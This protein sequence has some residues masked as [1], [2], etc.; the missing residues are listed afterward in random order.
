MVKYQ[1][2]RAS[3]PTMVDVKTLNISRDH[4]AKGLAV[5]L[6]ATLTQ[7]EL[8]S[9]FPPTVSMDTFRDIMTK[10]TLKNETTTMIKMKMCVQLAGLLPVFNHYDQDSSGFIEFHEFN[11][12][13]KE[14]NG[15]HNYTRD[16]LREK[17]RN[18]ALM[19]RHDTQANDEDVKDDEDYDWTSACVGFNHM[20]QLCILK[21]VRQVAYTSHRLTLA[22]RIWKTYISPTADLQVNIGGD[23]RAIIE[24]DL[25]Q[26]N[27]K[28]N[29]FTEAQEEIFKLMNRDSFKRFQ[30][31]PLFDEF[32]AEAG[33][34]KEIEKK[35][36]KKKTVIDDSMSNKMHIRKTSKN[37]QQ[38]LNLNVKDG[39]RSSLGV[40]LPMPESP[41]KPH[42]NKRSSLHTLREAPAPPQMERQHSM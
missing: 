42:L 38:E 21:R 30:Q 29:M 37:K 34:Y 3:T 8:E 1:S 19:T 28:P 36:T 9:T 33:Q 6:K 12:V 39:R 10:T 32:L 27:I 35:D 16:Q 15:N 24:S 14:Y 26:K 18:L 20:L 40:I 41:S 31:S 11:S 23:I 7:Q 2:P 17:F 25:S 13:L 5:S 4:V 22:T